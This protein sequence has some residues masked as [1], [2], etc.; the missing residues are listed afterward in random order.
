[1]LSYVFTAESA[2]SSAAKGAV[3][4]STTPPGSPPIRTQTVTSTEPV[5]DVQNALLALLNQVTS[6][7]KIQNQ[8]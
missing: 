1:M 5:A 7:P 4:Q 3:P 2:Q 8:K 6:A